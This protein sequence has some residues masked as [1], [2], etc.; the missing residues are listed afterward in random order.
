MLFS[1]SLPLF[2]YAYYLAIL[3]Q[4]SFAHTAAIFKTIRKHVHASISQA[5]IPTPKNHKTRSEQK[6][7]GST[8]ANPTISDRVS[9]SSK[10]VLT[11]SWVF[12]GYSAARD[13]NMVKIDA[14]LVL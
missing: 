11:T 10:Q 3:N 12:L 2:R 1:S 13:M 4:N 8:P 7:P 9:L 5:R 6:Y 14:S